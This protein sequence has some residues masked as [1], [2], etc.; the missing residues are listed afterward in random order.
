[1]TEPSDDDFRRTE[2]GFL[3]LL[4]RLRE[5]PE[6]FEEVPELE[7]YGGEK[8][9]RGLPPGAVQFVGAQLGRRIRFSQ[10]NENVGGYECIDATVSGIFIDGFAYVRLR[11]KIDGRNRN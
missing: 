4:E 7:T 3:D 9:I 8:Q 10:F 1:M 6:L 5:A 2:T 11:E